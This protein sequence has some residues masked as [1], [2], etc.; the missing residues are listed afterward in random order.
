MELEVGE[1][2]LIQVHGGKCPPAISDVADAVAKALEQPQA[3]PRLEQAVVP[4]DHVAIV[5]DDGIPEPG[6][7]L[8]PLLECLAD[9]GVARNDLLIVQV[10]R[11]EDGRHAL[12]PESLPPGIRLETHD[13]HD[14]KR[15]SYLASTKAGTRV[16]LNRE[17]VDADLVVLVGRVDY[18]PILGYRGPGSS[19]F[20]GLADAA[21]QHQFR[22][23]ISLIDEATTR[24]ALRRESDEVAW[25][26]GVQFAVQVVVGD[27]NEVIGVMAGRYAEVQTAAQGVLDRCWQGTVRQR[28]DMVI[29]SIGGDPSHQGFEELGMALDNARAVVRAGGRVAVLSA[30]AAA[31]GA[32]LGAARQLQN[33]AKALDIVRRQPSGDAISTWQILQAC[34]H[35]RVY[36]LSR[37]DN[38]LV[39]DLSMIPLASPNEIER[40][41]RE[42]DSCIVLNNAPLV[43]VTVEEQDD[44]SAR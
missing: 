22:G 26:L 5:L 29:A 10:P 43:H 21:A 41:V 38:E 30:I 42:S 18:H 28:A 17:V 6:T 35:A 44:E 39:Q 9:A 32:S 15:L 13:S 24:T 1:G 37:L 4:G 2:R 14:R 3:F 31:P 19:V 27:N 7:M 23:K 40:L 36:L 16:Y 8:G 12:T 20:P 34:Q 11:R 33:P 25:L